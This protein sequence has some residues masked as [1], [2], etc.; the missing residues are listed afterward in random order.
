MEQDVSTWLVGGGA[1]AVIGYFAR[2]LIAALDS[3]T[4]R[5]T[6]HATRITEHG[7]KLTNL[8]REVFK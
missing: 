2:R 6:D 1:L 8:E 4:D 5:L 3:V 7:V